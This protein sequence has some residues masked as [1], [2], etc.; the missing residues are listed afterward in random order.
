M[1]KSAAV[2]L[3]PA[4]GLAASLGL[5]LSNLYWIGFA[6]GR[7][8]EWILLCVSALFTAGAALAVCLLRRRFSFRYGIKAPAFFFLAFAPPL[9]LSGA[10]FA[11]VRLLPS[12]EGIAAALLAISWE[13]T[14][15]VFA[16]AGAA[17]LGIMGAAEKRKG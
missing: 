8:P 16:A 11:A 12:P 9:V 14:S 13:L 15:A 10:L 6:A 17:V 5:S 7:M 2:L 3:L 1:K 4:G